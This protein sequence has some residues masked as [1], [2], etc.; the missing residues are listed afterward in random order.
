MCVVK[1]DAKLHRTKDPDRCLQEVE[2][3]KK[4][5]YLKA[6]LQQRWHF[7]PFFASVDGLLGVEATAT[8]KR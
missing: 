8:L 4:R 6:C 1:N 5:L 2:R 3:E 7:F